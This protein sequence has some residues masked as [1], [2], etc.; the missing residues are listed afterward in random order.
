MKTVCRLQGH[1]STDETMKNQSVHD[2]EGKLQT[3]YEKGLVE[4]LFQ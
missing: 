2:Q 4:A 3:N 1:Q